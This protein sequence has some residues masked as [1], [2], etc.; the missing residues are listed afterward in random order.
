MSSLVNRQDGGHFQRRFEARYDS[1]AA[2]KG[3]RRRS[4]ILC[5]NDVNRAFIAVDCKVLNHKFKLQI[6]KLGLIA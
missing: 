5:V 6:D 4:K 1:E 3:A 2:P